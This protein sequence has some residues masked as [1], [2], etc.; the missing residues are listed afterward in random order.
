MN[1]RLSQD[2]GFGREWLQLTKVLLAVL[3]PAFCSAFDSLTFPTIPCKVQSDTSSSVKRRPGFRQ[4]GSTCDRTSRGRMGQE[5]P[6]GLLL[7]T[8]QLR[9]GRALLGRLAWQ[10]HGPQDCQ[11]TQITQNIPHF[12]VIGL[13]FD[14][15]RSSC[16]LT[17]ACRGR[18]HLL[19][20]ANGCVE[21]PLLL[22]P[23]C[24]GGDGRRVGAAA[25]AAGGGCSHRFIPGKV[26]GGVESL[27]Q[28]TLP[29]VVQG[30]LVWRQ[31]VLVLDVWAPVCGKN[32]HTCATRKREPDCKRKILTNHTLI[33]TG[34]QQN[35]RSDSPGF[36]LRAGGVSVSRGF[37]QK[38]S[39]TRLGGY[40]CT[41]LLHQFKNKHKFS[42]TA[43]L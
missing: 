38:K 34:K 26:V 2:G 20:H 21:N 39:S 32:L 6:E 12:H 5:V 7:Q 29:P 19:V 28:W 16:F 24:S 41:L 17:S 22:T 8:G 10:L 4:R 14:N 30:I 11:I 15:R 31:P 33:Q 40:L 9:L 3:P 23:G 36:T 35:L 13:F 18:R 42:I 25:A 27:T 37:T 43:L 1:S